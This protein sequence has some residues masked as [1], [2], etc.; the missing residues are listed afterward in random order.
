[1]VRFRSVL[2]CGVALTASNFAYQAANSEL[3]SVAI[4]RSYWECAALLI[5]W[6]GDHIILDWR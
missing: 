6:L 3:W 4:E 2:L 1:M 5:L